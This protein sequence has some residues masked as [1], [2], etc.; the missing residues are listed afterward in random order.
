MRKTINRITVVVLVLALMGACNNEPPECATE[1]FPPLHCQLSHLSGKKIDSTIIYLPDI[2]SVLY[3]GAGLPATVKIPLNI[4]TDTTFVQFTLIG[5]TTTAIEKENSVLGITSEPELTITNLE[6]GPFYCFRNLGYTLF[7]MSGVEPVYEIILD[8]FETNKT[9]YKYTYDSLG[10]A[11]DSTLIDE[12]VTV[13]DT[14]WRKIG[15]EAV[16]YQMSVDSLH[17]YT[18]EVDEEYEVHAKIF[19]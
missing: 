12:M 5:I 11:V 7:S 4:E 14:V 16:D 1:Q 15:V 2:D 6:C 10:L 8:T 9:Y 18:T 3:M 17:Y 13:V 19:F